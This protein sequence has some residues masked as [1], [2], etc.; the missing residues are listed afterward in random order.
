MP[1]AVAVLFFLLFTSLSYA[2]NAFRYCPKIR[3]SNE[4]EIQL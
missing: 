1:K 3:P 4:G 2:E